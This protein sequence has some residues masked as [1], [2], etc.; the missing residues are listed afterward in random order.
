VPQKPNGTNVYVYVHAYVE[1][2]EIANPPSRAA[3]LGTVH[4]HVHVHVHVNV[5]SYYHR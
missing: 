1:A 3:D 5:R 2:H 4:V